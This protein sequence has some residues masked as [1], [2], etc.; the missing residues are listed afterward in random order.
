MLLG[1]GEYA[2]TVNEGVFS[3]I[4]TPAGPSS[5]AFAELELMG[6]AFKAMDKSI[7]VA[8]MLL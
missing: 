7:Y 4:K 5:I 6:N 3:V 1:N 2:L 8:E